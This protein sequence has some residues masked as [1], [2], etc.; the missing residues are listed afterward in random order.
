VEA[1]DEVE[2]PPVSQGAAS[3]APITDGA[4]KVKAPGAP[5]LLTRGN[6]D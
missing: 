1:K 3:F 4:S 5:A 2:Q 6:S